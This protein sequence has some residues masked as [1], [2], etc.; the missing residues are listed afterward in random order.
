MA[1]VGTR[2]VTMSKVIRSPAFR[3]GFNDYIKGKPPQFDRDWKGDSRTDSTS[4]SWA[5]ERGRL[6]AAW[7]KS[8]DH[9]E[10]PPWFI[11]KRLNWKISWLV[12]EAH[13]EGAFR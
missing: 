13:Y 8:R 11:N 12:S 4:K 2:S 10:I 7:F 9:T 1:Q 6:F 5:Y 3:E